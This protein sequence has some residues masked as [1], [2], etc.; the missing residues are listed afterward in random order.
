MESEAQFRAG[1]KQKAYDAYQAGI[2]ANMEKLN[3][4][5]TAITRYTILPSVAVGAANLMLILVSRQ[6]PTWIPFSGLLTIL[7]WKYPPTE[8]IFLMQ[9]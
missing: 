2:T 7:P 6:I 3:L 1:Q 5:D 9:N 4:P 8:K